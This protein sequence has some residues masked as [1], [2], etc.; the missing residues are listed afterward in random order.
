MLTESDRFRP[1]PFIIEPKRWDPVTAVLSASFETAGSFG[2]AASE[3]VSKPRKPYGASKPQDTNTAALSPE[4]GEASELS[5]P[6]QDAALRPTRD[7]SEADRGGT[8][9]TLSKEPKKID[10]W[11]MHQQPEAPAAYFCRQ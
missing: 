6:A 10:N 4:E 5:Y 11:C 2:R 7:A 1:K 8:T 3:M 9:S